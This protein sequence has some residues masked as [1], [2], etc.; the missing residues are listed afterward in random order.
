[1]PWCACLVRVACARPGTPKDGDPT[2]VDSKCFPAV[3]SSIYLRSLPPLF[4]RP[5][6]TRSRSA[7]STC[8]RP[9]KKNT[10]RCRAPWKSWAAT[11]TD[12]TPHRSLPQLH[13]HTYAV[14]RSIHVAL[15]IGGAARRASRFPPTVAA[16]VG[17]CFFLR[18][19]FRGFHEPIQS[20]APRALR[21]C[22]PCL[23]IKRRAEG[24][25]SPESRTRTQ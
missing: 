22:C 2:A 5:R 14:P 21:G 23:L 9:R 19:R 16:T 4:R 1:M 18:A 13:G 3:A 12:G 6:S 20:P 10:R 17:A 8:V 15:A 11:A 25:A 7:A 24:P